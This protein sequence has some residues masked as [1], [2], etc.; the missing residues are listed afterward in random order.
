MLYV[1]IVV[2][3]FFFPRGLEEQATNSLGSLH[4]YTCLGLK[5]LLLQVCLL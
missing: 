2:F 1:N 3:F 5:D 4:G